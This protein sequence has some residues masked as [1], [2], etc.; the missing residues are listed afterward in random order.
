VCTSPDRGDGG[1]TS[2]VQVAT[3]WT[4][5]DR[6]VGPGDLSGDGVPDV[7]ARDA[8]TGTLFLLRGTGRSA[9][10]FQAP[11]QVGTG[12]RLQRPGDHRRRHRR[13][14]PDP[15]AHTNGGVLTLFAGT[16]KLTP[17]VFAPAVTIGGG[18]NVHDVLG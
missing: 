13:R 16:G 5:Y 11:L 9:T 7:L 3:G 17:G 2:P 8:R 6:I 1:F 10:P 12:G 15:L 4:R 14:P 18:G